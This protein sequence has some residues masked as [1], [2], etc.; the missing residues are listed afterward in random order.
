MG[1]VHILFVHIYSTMHVFICFVLLLSIS[2][3]LFVMLDSQIDPILFNV[4]IQMLLVSHVTYHSL[5]TLGMFLLKERFT[6]LYTF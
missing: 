2:W 3:C 4:I 6:G 1:Y 5:P